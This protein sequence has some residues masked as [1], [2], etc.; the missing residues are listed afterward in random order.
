LERIET[1]KSR[2]VRKSSLWLCDTA[3]QW[4]LLQYSF[5]RIAE[6]SVNDKRWTALNHFVSFYTQRLNF[7]VAPLPLFGYTYFASGSFSIYKRLSF[8]LER[9]Y[10]VIS[11]DKADPPIFW[12]IAAHEFSHC[13]LGRREDVDRICSN[14]PVGASRIDRNVTERRVEEAICDALATRIIGPAYPYSYLH[15]LWAQFP[16]SVDV[17][18][19]SHRFRIKCMAKV[20]E[21]IE[22]Y[23]SAKNLRDTADA[24]FSDPWQDEDISW[25]INDIVATTSEMPKFVTKDIESDA[26]K[27]A[28]S[29]HASPPKDLPTLFLA[30][31]TLVD[32]LGAGKVSSSMVRTTDAILKVLEG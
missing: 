5:F 31:W 29:L 16:V 24:I 12:P 6:A 32:N 9:E 8:R 7:G 10:Y 11:V 20:L 28:E 17:T 22:L 2:S 21:K 3:L 23:E 26:K 14:Q 25:A 13:W 1:S 19:P 27:A 18:Y 15:K 4:L 30:C